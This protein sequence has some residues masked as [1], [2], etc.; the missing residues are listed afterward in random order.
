MSTLTTAPDPTSET[1]QLVRRA[2]R[3]RSRRALRRTS[4]LGLLLAAAVVVRVTLGD[5][6]VTIPDTLRIIGGA[7]IPGASFILMESTLPRAVAA[8]LAGASL[9]VAGGVMQDLMRNPLASPDILGI[10]G[11]ASTAAVFSLIVLGLSGPGVTMVAFLG[12]LAVAA[13]LVGM[14]SG[15]AKGGTHA[16]IIVGVGCSALLVALTHWVLLRADVYRLSEAMVWL[17]GSVAAASWTEIA[18]LAVLAAVA[19]PAMLLLHRQL[20]V[21]M[22]GD[23]LAAG[24]GVA[25]E[26]HRALAMLGV[27]LLVAGTC[28]VCGPIAFVALLAGPIGRRLHRGRTRL[29]DI[30]LI[31][32]LMVVVADYIGAYLVPGGGNLPVGVVT[33]LAGAPFLLWL[34][35]T[36]TRVET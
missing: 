18:R 27:V 16:L 4:A 8:V 5:Y 21:M 10:S 15:G 1:A 11:G 32:A 33:G 26:R 13:V 34:I 35:V 14:S 17:T 22:L 9:A 29:V 36:R 12:A 3:H 30:A 23:D 2:R 28:A 7:D 19:L 24:L 31:G 6:T 25:V 20:R